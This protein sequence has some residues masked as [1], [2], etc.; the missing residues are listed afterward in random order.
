MA[1]PKSPKKTKIPFYKYFLHTITDTNSTI[2]DCGPGVAT[3]AKLLSKKGKL[4]YKNM[5][6]CEIYEPYVKQYGLDQW[7]RN[8][9]I[10]DICDFKFDWYDIIIMGDILEH[11]EQTKAQKLIKNIYGKCNHLIIV[12]PFLYKQDPIPPNTYLAHLQSDLTEKVFL[13]RYPGFK[14]LIEIDKIGIF[15]KEKHHIEYEN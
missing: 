4:I 3:Y 8:V 13:N 15:V 5:D 11:I 6:C 12:V 7:Y 9:F 2:L 10:S 1:K 14:M